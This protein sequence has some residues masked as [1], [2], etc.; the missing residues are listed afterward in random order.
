M[1]VIHLPAIDKTVSLK[2]Y[3]AAIKLAKANPDQEFKHGL[4]C[5]WACTGKDIMR[6]FWEGTQDRINQAIPYTERK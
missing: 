2:A 3:V 6:Q 5:W 1:R 4:T